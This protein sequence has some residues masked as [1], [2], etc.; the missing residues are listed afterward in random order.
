MAKRMKRFLF[1]PL[2]PPVKS[3][4]YAGTDIV[5][6]L[7]TSKLQKRFSAI[8]TV[9][10]E[11][12][13]ELHSHSVFG[14]LFND[15]TIYVF[16][17]GERRKS[18]AQLQRLLNWLWEHE[19]DRDSLL[20][21][22]GGGVVTDITGFAASCYLRGIA[23]ISIPTT[24][25]TQIDAA[26]GGKTAVNLRDTK[27]IIGNFHLPQMVI[28]DSRLLS[29]LRTEQIK[30]GLVEAIKVFAAS[31]RRLFEKHASNLQSLIVGQNLNHLIADSINA[32]L[33]IVNA[34]PFEKGLRRMLNFGHTTGHAVEA[35]VGWSHGKSV[36]FGMLVALMLSQRHSSL[37]TKDLNQIWSVIESLYSHFNT[38][39]LDAQLLWDK[40]KHDKKRSGRQINFVLLPRCGTHQ[41]V[42]ITCVQF[43]RALAETRERIS[44]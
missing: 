29:S 4:I 34:D 12:V 39:V 25:L 14:H 33:A 23:Y 7:L 19:A 43:S 36:A 37:S 40:I 35:V 42:P 5:D 10:D 15:V 31:D 38:A 2:N 8:Y 1:T 11:R 27:N 26:I 20:L 32:K 21:G 9:V 18:L 22:I 44:K 17:R 6:R 28:C 16:P 13:F 41:I 24:L 30:Q 3:P